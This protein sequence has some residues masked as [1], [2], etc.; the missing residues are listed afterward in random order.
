[1]IHD[2]WGLTVTVYHKGKTSK[3]GKEY[4]I[5]HR[6]TAENCFY[7]VKQTT[8]KNGNDVRTGQTAI[9]RIPSV[10][11]QP[12]SVGDIVAVGMTM[13]VIDDYGNGITPKE[14]LLRY[15]G[16]SLQ[17]NVAHDNTSFPFLPHYYGSD[18]SG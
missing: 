1:M 15:P 4:T 9:V 13:D 11:K 6:E 18:S 2:Y 16:K 7:Q 3:D 5:Y 14:F 10:L 8:T 17:V 12:L